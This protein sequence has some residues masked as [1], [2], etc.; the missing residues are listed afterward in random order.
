LSRSVPSLHAPVPNVILLSLLRVAIA[1][2]EGVPPDTA[3]MMPVA[4][5]AFYQS[6][7]DL[8]GGSGCCCCGEGTPPVLLLLGRALA[9]GREERRR[10]SV[11][12]AAATEQVVEV[13][14]LRLMLLPVRAITVLRGWRPAVHAPAVLPVPAA[15]EGKPGR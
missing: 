5:G 9:R 11:H 14:V 13:V 3:T 8:T 1:R 10:G 7:V 12:T 6:G 2:H 4:N 15:A